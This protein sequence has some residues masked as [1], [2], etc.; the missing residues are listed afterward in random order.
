MYR[1]ETDSFIMARERMIEN[2]RKAGMYSG[3]VIKAMANVP[4]HL[5]VSEA[6]R[7]RAYDDRPLPIGYNQTIT[8]PSTVAFMV[9][10]LNLTGCETVLE[11]GTGSG[12]QHR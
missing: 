5:F 4:R 11:I 2:I 10:A 8:K 12:Y 3:N 9:Q 1:R 7:F 6:L